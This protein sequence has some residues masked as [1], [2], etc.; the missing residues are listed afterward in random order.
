MATYCGITPA[1]NAGYCMALLKVSN[2][3]TTKVSFRRW[4]T[5][6]KLHALLFLKHGILCAVPCFWKS[7]VSIVPE[8][9]IIAENDGSF[10][11]PCAHP[12]DVEAQ[13]KTF[14]MNL[15][16]IIPDDVFFMYT[17]SLFR[18]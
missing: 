8:N 2:S 12:A 4:N 6:N 11:S 18:R 15:A 1:D 10:F 9:T 16:G 14:S 7:N 13:F 3:G 5:R 17:A